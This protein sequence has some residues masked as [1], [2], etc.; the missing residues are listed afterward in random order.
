MASIMPQG[1]TGRV[2]VTSRYLPSRELGGDSFDD[3]WIDDDHLRVYLIDISGH[4]R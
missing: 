3:S 4:P 2:G 1:I